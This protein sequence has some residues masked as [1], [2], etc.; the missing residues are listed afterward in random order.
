MQIKQFNYPINARPLVLFSRTRR[1]RRRALAGQE[2]ISQTAGK[3]TESNPISFNIMEDGAEGEPFAS[4]QPP[5]FSVLKELLFP[6]CLETDCSWSAMSS[7]LSK[8]PPQQ[9]YTINERAGHAPPSELD[10]RQISRLQPAGR[11]HGVPA[12]RHSE[13]NRSSEG[14]AGRCSDS[15]DRPFGVPSQECPEGPY[16]STAPQTAILYFL[17]ETTKL[18]PPVTA[19]KCVASIDGSPFGNARQ[20]QAQYPPADFCTPVDQPGTWCG[21]QPAVY[22]GSIRLVPRLDGCSSL[23]VMSLISLQCN[24]LMNSESFVDGVLQPLGNSDQ[25]NGAKAGITSEAISGSFGM[26]MDKGTKEMP[27]LGCVGHLCPPVHDMGSAKVAQCKESSNVSHS[28][29]NKFLPGGTKVGTYSV[30]TLAVGTKEAEG[31]E[32]TLGHNNELPVGRQSATMKNT[33]GV[34][35]SK[36]TI[37]ILK[38]MEGTLSKRGH[39]GGCT[40]DTPHKGE[41]HTTHSTSQ[42]KLDFNS[43]EL[44]FS[45]KGALQ[46][47]GGSGLIS[48]SGVPV[49]GV[50]QD[51]LTKVGNQPPGQKESGAPGEGSSRPRKQ[52][53]QQKPMKSAKSWDPDFRGVTI[54]MQMVPSSE[55]PDNYQLLITPQYSAELLNL[56]KKTRGSKAR[57]AADSGRT[58]SSEEDGYPL[59]PNKSKVCASCSTRKTPLWRDA[60]DGTP[61]CN[62]CGIRY[63]KYRVRCFRCWHIPKK[64]GNSNF[65]CLRCGGLLRVSTSQRKNS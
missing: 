18:V 45:A 64:D 22:S 39:A 58:S 23:D 52:R 9:H 55:S 59:C 50:E 36:G 34:T 61:L 31:K 8:P 44:C 4:D 46:D 63:K 29:D 13:S 16:P 41:C 57:L 32:F 49:A 33:C 3:D 53:K 43:N 38:Q 17:Q 10:C 56:T 7:K 26:A 2:R 54:T 30:G 14:V 65:K 35:A 42:T 62:A 6:A 48:H 1:Q 12:A 20:P 5:D 40:E 37:N 24:R 51:V 28:V 19:S 21:P 15:M 47:P 60:E 25:I 27:K 11:V